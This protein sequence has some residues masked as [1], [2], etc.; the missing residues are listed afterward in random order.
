MKAIS[1]IIDIEYRD[2][3]LLANSFKEQLISFIASNLLI[4]NN[5]EKVFKM[6]KDG[7]KE[8]D[9]NIFVLFMYKTKEG[10]RR[11]FYQGIR[12]ESF[13]NI[14]MDYNGSKVYR[15]NYLDH[16]SIAKLKQTSSDQIL[17]L[18]ISKIPYCL[19]ACGLFCR[20]MT[21]YMDVDTEVIIKGLLKIL[22]KLDMIESEVNKKINEFSVRIKGQSIKSITKLQNLTK[23]QLCNSI[24]L[25]F[26][27]DV[28]GLIPSNF[29]NFKL[30]KSDA[31]QSIP[32]NYVMVEY[33]NDPS[34]CR[35]IDKLF[36][37]NNRYRSSL[38][39]KN[40]F[41]INFAA[42]DRRFK[43]KLFSIG[44]KQHAWHGTEKKNIASILVRGLLLPG[45]RSENYELNYGPGI[46][47]SSS[48]SKS[49]R[50]CKDWIDKSSLHPTTN[51]LIF[52]SV[53][54]GRHCVPTKNGPYP[55]TGFDSVWA[56]RLDKY[57]RDELVVYSE[58]QVRI[59]YVVE[60]EKYKH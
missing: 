21:L 58:D 45:E 15:S 22:D 49:L 46:Y 27:L 10:L 19:K 60:V 2:K 20:N 41:K 24:L 56:H 31:I 44:N 32:D 12:V 6:S 18:P 29:N 8:R 7:A 59:D 35:Y 25:R 34:T 17:E 28:H 33:V 23:V 36:N 43:H 51:F 30:N 11:I 5:K 52:A 13:I 57:Y 53:A 48:P 39:I 38:R 4:M 26:I 16:S 1:T 9:C 14:F 3:G 40:I 55:T 42:R 54:V 50:Y 47:F 37:F